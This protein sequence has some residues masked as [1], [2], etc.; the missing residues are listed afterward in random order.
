MPAKKTQAKPAPKTVP[1]KASA[2]VP[3]AAP[4]PV[5]VA[6]PEPTSNAKAAPTSQETVTLNFTAVLTNLAVLTKQSREVT[7][8]VKQ[9]QKNVAKERRELEKASKGRKKKNTGDKSKRAPSGFAKPTGLS[10]EL[11]TFLGVS[12]DTQLARTEVTKNITTYVKEHDLQNPA[13]KKQ[14]NPDAKLGKL[15]KVP[16]GEI[17]TYFNLQKYMKNHFQKAVPTTPVVVTA[18]APVPVVAST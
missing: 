18:P 1:K 8:Q 5:V 14:I 6:A 15:L 9:L 10:K 16:K 7:A 3:A 4:A 12:N 13:N 2:P 17:L 11:C